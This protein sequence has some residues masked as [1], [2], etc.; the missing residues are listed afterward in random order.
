[1]AVGVARTIAH[2]QNTTRIV[3][4][5]INSPDIIQVRAAAVR[6]ITTIQ[7]AQRSAIPTI[8]AFPASA[9]RTSRIIR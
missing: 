9:D 8:L 3:T 2:G 6:A 5:R 4:A 7:V 1:M